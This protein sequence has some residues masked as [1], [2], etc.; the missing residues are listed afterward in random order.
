MVLVLFVLDTDWDDRSNGVV[1]AVVAVDWLKK[2]SLI[3]E[4]LWISKVSLG[5]DKHLIFLTVSSYDSELED[6]VFSQ[7]KS[8]IIA[9]YCSSLSLLSRDES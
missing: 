1:E 4:K 6:E 5:G 3:L 2:S 7:S 8:D 9:H